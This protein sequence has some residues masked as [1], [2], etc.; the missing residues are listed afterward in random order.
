[1]FTSWIPINESMYEGDKKPFAK[2]ARKTQV[3]VK[4]YLS[5]LTKHR[6]MDDDEIEEIRE[7]KKEEMRKQAK[8]QA[9]QEKQEQEVERQ[10]EAILK[11]YTTSDAR[12]R[13]NTV[14]MV[15]KELAEK[16]RQQVVAIAARG[17][18]DEQKPD[19]STERTV[20]DE[21]EMKSILDELKP[22]DDGFNI[23]RR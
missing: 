5:V 4:T 12:K 14:E 2:R 18:L 23:K 15:N 7:R 1:M 9:Q 6:D 17:H 21:S 20:I 13:L 10:K 11:Q 3:C 16:A 22:D 8:K 19:G